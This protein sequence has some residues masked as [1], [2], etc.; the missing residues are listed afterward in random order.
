MI[1]TVALTNVK[2]IPVRGA[3]HNVYVTPDGSTL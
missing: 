2:S 3:I 1:D